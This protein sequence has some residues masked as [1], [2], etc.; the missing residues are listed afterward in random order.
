MGFLNAFALYPGLELCKERFQ[1]W[2]FA[3][4]PSLLI[5]PV[6]RNLDAFFE[7][8]RS[9]RPRQTRSKRG[10]SS[11]PLVD[12]QGPVARRLD[13]TIPQINHYPLDKC[14]NSDLSGG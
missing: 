6:K 1:T 2:L 5:F 8:I 4:K 7:Y 14:R 11:G 10:L 13:N 3:L 12:D 9:R